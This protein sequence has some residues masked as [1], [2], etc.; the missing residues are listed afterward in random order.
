MKHALILTLSLALW[1]VPSYAQERAADVARVIEARVGADRVAEWIKG[2]D[3][4][5]EELVEVAY[6]YA[7]SQEVTEAA[8]QSFVRH[9]RAG[10]RARAFKDIWS[11]DLDGDLSVTRTE[12][13]EIALALS[14][15]QRGMLWTRHR[16]ADAN[17]DGTVTLDELSTYAE[18]RALRYL[19]E[20]R[21]DALNDALAL[22]LD[23]N[24]AVSVEEAERA[25][26]LLAQAHGALQ[27]TTAPASQ[28]DDA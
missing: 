28:D 26:M 22:D 6:G 19:S 10:A 18:T 14:G 9:G 4:V 2:A 7:P 25:L 23:G 24:G 8:I 21:A 3:W 15:F 13:A 11:A 27:S 16:R 17:S 20:T 1:A 5:I 12:I